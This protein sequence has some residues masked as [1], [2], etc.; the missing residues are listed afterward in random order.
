M[1]S[2]VKQQTLLPEPRS[3]NTCCTKRFRGLSNK[4]FW[5]PAEFLLFLPVVSVLNIYTY[6]HKR[7]CVR[8]CIMLK[9][10]VIFKTR[11]RTVRVLETEMPFDRYHIVCYTA[12]V[13]PESVFVVDLSVYW[14]VPKEPC[15]PRVIY[16]HFLCTVT[17]ET[18]PDGVFRG[19][20]KDG[21]KT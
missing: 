15:V 17:G 10:K 5:V 12:Q 7:I 8:V 1:V 18:K 14:S 6:I 16:K 9:G 13:W 2:T 3:S 19:Q 21:W 20:K 11:L 4:T